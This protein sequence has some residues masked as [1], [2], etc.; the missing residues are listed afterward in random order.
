MRGSTIDVVSSRLIAGI[1]ALRRSLGLEQTERQ[2]PG[3][4]VSQP[5]KRVAAPQQI[6]PAKPVAP[7]T[8]PKPASSVTPT[9]QTTASFLPSTLPATLVNPSRQWIDFSQITAF[10]LNAPRG[11]YLD[12]VA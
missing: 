2:L 6:T 4:P 3:S 10:D 1:L 5:E 7:T 12:I 11:T 8:A 9:A